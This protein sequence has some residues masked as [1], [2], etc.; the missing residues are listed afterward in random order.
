MTLIAYARTS[1]VEQ[2]GSLET[3]VAR[4]KALG[5]DSDLIFAEQRSGSNADRPKLK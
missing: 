1:T 3:Q 4:F 5:V 2:S